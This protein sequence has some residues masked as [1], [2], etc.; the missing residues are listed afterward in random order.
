MNEAVVVIDI[1]CFQHRNQACVVKEMAVYGDYL[2]SIVF[3]E[4]QPFH[5][6]PFIVQK[7]YSW[8]TNNLHGLSWH[9][10]DYPYDRL[11]SF[12]ESIKLR[13]PKSFLFAKGLEKSK[14]LS[15]LF[16]RDFYDL[17]DFGCPRI[18]QL[19]HSNIYCRSSSPAR[20]SGTHCARKK[21]NAFGIWIQKYFAE[22]GTISMFVT[23]C[24]KTAF[25][26]QSTNSNTEADPR[27]EFDSTQ[28]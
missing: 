16:E 18:D 25:G 13:Y 17:N 19:K 14:F 23:I 2:D 9:T 27:K 6:L 15:R 3:R 8:L 26:W 21:A 7:I 22:H 11:L 10:G 12:V 5:T 20:S 1:E 24:N 4:A 28:I